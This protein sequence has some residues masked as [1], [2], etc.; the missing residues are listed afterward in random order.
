M[1]C[2]PMQLNAIKIFLTQPLFQHSKLTENLSF[3]FLNAT[4]AN[5][6]VHMQG[7]SYN[8]HISAESFTTP[9]FLIVNLPVKRF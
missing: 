5:C 8:N 1:K 3:V 4:A 7:T 9:S 6:S 2:V